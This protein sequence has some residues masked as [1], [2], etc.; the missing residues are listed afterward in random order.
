MAQIRDK[1]VVVLGASRGVGREIALRAHG[2]GGQVLAIA[3]GEDELRRLAGDA[4]GIDVF[5]LD[6]ASEDAPGRVFARMT[7]DILAIVNGTIV[8]LAGLA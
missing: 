4:P 8:Q 7:P 1:N 3:R 5:A 6:A 2:V